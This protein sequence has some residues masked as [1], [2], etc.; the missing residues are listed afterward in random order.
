MDIRLRPV[1]P[2]DAETLEAIGP[3]YE[4]FVGYGG[5]PASY[6]VGGPDWAAGI[7][8]LVEEAHWGRI[9]E[10]DGSLSGEVK[11][12]HFA[13][14]THSARLALGL[15]QPE[16]RNCGIGRRVI[17]LCLAEAF[18]QL[19]LHRVSLRVLTKN[20]RA[21]RCY[22]AAGFVHEGRLR[23][24]ARVGDGYEDELVMSVLKTDH[25]PVAS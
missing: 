3:D 7:L 14:Q 1:V 15:F 22:E 13:P 9:V 8:R 12:H 19:D 5:D 20:T 24:A 25:R 21:I 23:E 2:G 18:G 10:V 17:A 16:M 4:A 6:P 11:L